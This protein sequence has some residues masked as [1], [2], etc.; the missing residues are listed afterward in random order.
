M[1]YYQQRQKIKQQT[2]RLLNQCN[3]LNHQFQS[4]DRRRDRDIYMFQHQNEIRQLQNDVNQI[5]SCGIT[6]S[7]FGNNIGCMNNCNQA[8]CINHHSTGCIN[9]H[10]I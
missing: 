1:N 4:W 6:P 10:S 7:G 5:I 2:N 3:T 9:H 8:A